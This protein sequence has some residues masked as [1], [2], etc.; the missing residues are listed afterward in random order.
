[1]SLDAPVAFARYQNNG[2]IKRYLK[3][4]SY[5]LTFASARKKKSNYLQQAEFFL[6]LLEQYI[7]KG[8]WFALHLKVS[9]T[10]NY[11]WKNAVKFLTQDTWLLLTTS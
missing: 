5:P 10:S 7:K 11:W 1:M 9:I 3:Q 8:L 2:D 4:P 6:L